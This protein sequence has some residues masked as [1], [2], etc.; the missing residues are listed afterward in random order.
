MM[1][2]VTANGA[3]E[4]L[5]RIAES[6]SA[7]AAQLVHLD[8]ENTPAYVGDDKLERAFD[9]LAELLID[10]NEELNKFIA[11]LERYCSAS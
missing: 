7:L 1:C 11:F 4:S 3:L 5:R 8:D 9:E 2:S 10:Q 6:K